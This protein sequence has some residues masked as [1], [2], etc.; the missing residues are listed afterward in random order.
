MRKEKIVLVLMATI[1]AVS[2]SVLSAS[3][4]QFKIRIG[5][6]VTGSTNTDSVLLG[7]SGDG[8]GGTI[9]DNTYGPDFILA[10]GSLG[11]WRETI[12]PPPP[13]EY[14]FLTEWLDIP[15][16]SE[17]P[18]GLKYWD[19]RGYT[20]ETQIDSFCFRVY[21]SSTMMVA[22]GEI[23][24]HWPGNLLSYG[25]LWELKKYVGPSDTDYVTVVPD[26]A[27]DP[28]LSWT[29]DNTAE[30][31]EVRYLIIKYGAFNL[32]NTM[33]YSLSSGWNLVSV[34]RVQSD[35]NAEVVF[36]GKYGS[37]FSYDPVLG[38]Y[39]GASTLALGL[40]YWVYYIDATTITFYGSAPAPIVVSCKAGWNLI[41]SR[42][43]EVQVADL[44]L[45][46]GSIYG[47]VFRYDT[48]IQDY[49]ATAVI[50][51]AEGIWIYLTE[52]CE[53]TIP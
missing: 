35:Y 33:Y 10:Y 6:D 36:P 25:T 31:N 51:P 44:Q 45:S 7:V 21:G 27:T 26:M 14:D 3:R 2:N 8:P 28:D 16:R 53:L 22:D 42:E 49:A 4:V 11:R 48:N 52:N 24:L 1:L 41:G 13:F 30:D 20:S 18:M 19:F 47:S 46:A 23:T 32:E 34:P 17:L 40:G 38:D 15:G 9:L 39:V 29:D 43:R 12:P 5:V 50:Y 37:M